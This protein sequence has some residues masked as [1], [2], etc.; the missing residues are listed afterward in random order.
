MEN[1]IQLMLIDYNTVKQTQLNNQ[2]FTLLEILVVLFLIA[3]ILTM[4]HADYSF[5]I[6]Q[7]MA[8]KF[9]NELIQNIKH[10]R[11][12]A[13]ATGQKLYLCASKNQSTCS[14]ENNWHDGY[15][16]TTSTDAATTTNYTHYTKG[17]KNLSVIK[18]GIR[19]FLQIKA[20]GHLENSRFSICDKP[21]Q[22]AYSQVVLFYSGRIRAEQKKWE[23]F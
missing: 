15:L 6:N 2:G 3:L 8:N 4:S 22:Y 9:K 18:N 14:N 19:P 12:L 13:L 17:N 1:N 10:A 7:S 11:Q 20:N 21:N 23:C 5:K 16:I